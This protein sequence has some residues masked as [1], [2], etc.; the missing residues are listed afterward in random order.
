MFD[1]M[2]Y[3]CYLRRMKRLGFI[4]TG[5]GQASLDYIAVVDGYPLEDTKHEAE[6]LVVAGGGPVATALVSMSRLK[7]K[8]FLMGVV[9]HDDAGKTIIKGLEDEGVDVSGVKVRKDGES[10]RAFIIVNSK[11][12]TRTIVWKRPSARMLAAREVDSARITGS[13]MLILDGL[14]SEA[15]L[16]AASIA[17]KAGVPVLLDAG[18]VREG[19]MELVAISDYVVGSSEFAAGLG[20]SPKEAVERLSALGCKAATITL[21]R[22]GSVTFCEGRLIIQ[23]G[24]DVD[25]LDTTGAG[26][27]FHGGYAYGVL[28]GWTID[29]TLEFASAFAAIKSMSIGGRVGIP[30]LGR[31]M[32]FIREKG[33]CRSNGR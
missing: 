29:E 31:T 8:A 20:L 23:K 18:R 30:T 19:M 6:R 14:M 21:G 1:T 2:G 32:R 24:F 22:K 27:V 15:S 4:V 11:D 16:K 33:G 12:G 13:D 9:G 10:Q 3:R 25:T 5:I 26:D 7:V 28:M 17:R